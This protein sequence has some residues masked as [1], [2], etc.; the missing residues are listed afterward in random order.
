MSGGTVSTSALGS[1]I[2]G[3]KTRKPLSASSSSLQLAP[4]VIPSPTGARSSK[5]RSRVAN[6]EAS[7]LTVAS[8]LA[9]LGYRDRGL[10][11]PLAPPSALSVS[12]FGSMS[13]PLY[14]PLSPA[15]VGFTVNRYAGEARRCLAWV[16]DGEGPVSALRMDEAWSVPPPAPHEVCSL[17][18]TVTHSF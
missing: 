17:Q 9:P 12:T 4:V 11:S 1:P 14:A 2:M 3:L 5:S 8:P 16:V 18:N 7:A 13:S 15:A 10:A 6:P